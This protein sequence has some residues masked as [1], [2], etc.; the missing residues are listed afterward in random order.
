MSK[1]DRALCIICGARV[2]NYKVTDICDTYC[3]QARDLGITREEAICRSIDKDN[4]REAQ[5]ES[6]R[7][8]EERRFIE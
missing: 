8:Q 6:D 1:Q 3:R 4:E 5:R 7:R 2:V